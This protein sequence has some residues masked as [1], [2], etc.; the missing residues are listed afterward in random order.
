MYYFLEYL[1]YKDNLYN[2]YQFMHYLIL[3]QLLQKNG[4]FDILILKIKKC[5]KKNINIYFD[6]WNKIFINLIFNKIKKI[7]IVNIVNPIN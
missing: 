1:F 7:N 2:N 6:F 4:F 5:L 3:F